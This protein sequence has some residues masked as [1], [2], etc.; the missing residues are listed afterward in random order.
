MLTEL[1]SLGVTAE[2]LRANISSKSVISL[3]RGP[4]DPKFQL[5]GVAPTN[6]SSSQKTKL[7]VLV[8]Y[9]NLERP[10]FC[11]VTIHA[12]DRWTDRR[13]ESFL[14]AI[15]RLHSMRRGK[16]CCDDYITVVEGRPIISVKYCLSVSVFY[17]WAKL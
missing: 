4:V 11:F 3:Q 9:K 2:V 7:N 8:W 17:F 10:F 12:F 14:I 5:E 1:I 6:H 13:T 15:P 16:N